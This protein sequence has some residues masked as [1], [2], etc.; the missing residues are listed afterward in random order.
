MDAEQKEL[1]FQLKEQL[2]VL[3]KENRNLK[4]KLEQIQYISFYSGYG[5]GTAD[6]KLSSIIGI[7]EEDD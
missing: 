5:D 7:L 4:D 3:R 2:E 1:I 6:D